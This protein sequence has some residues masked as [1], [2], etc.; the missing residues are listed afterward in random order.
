M[1]IQCQRG[2][3]RRFTL[4]GQ[5]SGGYWREEPGRGTGCRYSQ[6]RNNKAELPIGGV[7]C[8]PDDCDPRG[9]QARALGRRTAVGVCRIGMGPDI[10]HPIHRP[11]CR[12]LAPRMCWNLRWRWRQSQE[13]L[14]W[15]DGPRKGLPDARLE[16]LPK[17]QAKRPKE[18]VR[19]WTW[20]DRSIS[21][22]VGGIEGGLPHHSEVIP[23]DSARLCYR[24]GERGEAHRARRQ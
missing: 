9:R 24:R 19:K 22:K 5:S 14:C 11:P 10:V 6:G 18:L 16:G 21:T 7:L 13:P 20:R 17:A 3:E 23:G 12:L 4:S 8:R 2:S 15:G 1:A